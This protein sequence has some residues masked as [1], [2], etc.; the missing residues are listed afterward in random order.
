MRDR[1]PR[2]TTHVGLE[3]FSIPLGETTDEAWSVAFRIKRHVVAMR[4]AK[5]QPE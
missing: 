2:P 3:L 5:L 4:S 1:R